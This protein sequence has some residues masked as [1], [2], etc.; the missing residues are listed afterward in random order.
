MTLRARVALTAA[1]AAAVAVLAA[2]IGLYVTTARTLRGSV[3]RALVEL[4][5]RLEPVRGARPSPFGPRPGSLGGAGGFVQLV[6]ARGEV[7]RP[8]RA[9][10]EALPVS[11]TTLAVAA[12]ERPASFATIDVRGDPVRILTVPWRPGVALQVAR[13]LWE[14]EV[15]L[16]ALRRRLGLV[17]VAGIALA[18]MLGTL[19]ARRAVRPVKDLTD[20][21][22]EVATTQDLS[23]RVEIARD[24]EIGRLARTLNTMLANLEEARRAQEQ[25][26]ADASHELRTP[27]TSLRTNVEVLAHSDRLGEGDRRRLI[28]DVVIQLDEFARLVSGLVELARGAEPA[29]TTS[30]VRLDE[31]VQEV[32]GRTRAYAGGRTI[33]VTA[34]PTTVLAEADRLERAVVNLL[35]NAVKYGGQGPI[36]VDVADGRVTVRDHG[37]GIA[38]EDLARVFDRF[39]RAASARSQPG[40]GLGLSIVQQ[41]AHSQGG[42]VRA[43]NAPGGGAVVTLELPTSPAPVSP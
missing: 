41:V 6:T 3:D 4:A 9:T 15:T 40:S 10:A 1:L 42:S 21:A 24:D 28:D 18:G 7:L 32:A 43:A 22:E 34:T 26:V 33:D 20:V 37:P 25:L 2:S 35:D 8:R 11:D 14:V 19:V 16:A 5:G 36:E 39:Y 30:P 12:G 29:R 27:L 38:D 17:G 13:P 23:R 31:L